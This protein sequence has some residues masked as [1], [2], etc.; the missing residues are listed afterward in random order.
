[1]SK[2]LSER[3]FRAFYVYQSIIQYP[4]WSIGHQQTFSILSCPGLTIST[5]AMSCLP[6][7]VRHLLFSTRYPLVY[8][9]SFFL[10]VPIQCKQGMSLLVH[11]K[12]VSKPSPSS[13]LDFFYNATDSC[14]GFYFLVGDPM[15][16]TY[17]QNSSKAPT[18]ESSQLAFYLFGGAPCFCSIQ[19]H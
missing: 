2:L 18:L 16:P 19:Q 9:C 10:G 11:S 6:L 17:S 4:L 7:S 14:S 12:G 15:L 1:M 3:M 8:P 5:H 13:F